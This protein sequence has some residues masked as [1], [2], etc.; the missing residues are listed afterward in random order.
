MTAV[1]LGRS[2]G[3]VPER[4]CDVT[5]SDF[6]RECRQDMGADRPLIIEIKEGS[7]GPVY[8]PRF[9]RLAFATAYQLRASV[10]R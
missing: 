6:A 10:S 1:C 8:F 4:L 3:F 5:T 2:L 9:S 7:Y